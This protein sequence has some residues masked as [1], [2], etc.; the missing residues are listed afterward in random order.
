VYIAFGG[1]GS[2]HVFK[3]TDAG[4]SWNDVSGILPD[5]PATAVFVDPTNS[6]HVYVGTDIGVY[7]S[8]NGGTDWFTFNEGLPEAVLIS[9]LNISSGHH[10]LRAVTHGNGVY[11]RSISNILIDQP[12]VVS[13]IPDQTIAPGGKF[14][15]IRA[16]NYVIDPDNAD[17]SITWSWS[18]NSNLTVIWIPNGRRIRVR[19]PRNWTGSET[20]TFTATDP[21]GL[22]DSDPATFTVTS[23]DNSPLSLLPGQELSVE[24]KTLPNAVE[25]H[26]AYPNPFNPSTTIRY[27]LPEDSWVSLK[28]YNSIGEEVRTL[29]NEF[30]SAGF[31]SVTWNGKNES[32][33]DVSSGMYIYTLRVGQIVKM[34]KVLLVR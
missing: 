14:S 6:S 18:G 12:P 19:G 24:T 21:D 22:S 2:S 34:E 4:T 20:I 29:V 30:Q 10:L 5:V 7:L 1:F 17:S 11:E 23:K 33:N 32:G 13:D 3:S 15:P 25:L 9:D 28:L 31:R 27:D 26:T 8:T 16:D